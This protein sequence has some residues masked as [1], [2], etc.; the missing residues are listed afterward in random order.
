MEHDFDKKYTLTV[1]E[2]QAVLIKDAL[3]EYFRIRMNQW[4]GLAESLVM[5]NI[6]LSTD[7][8]NHEKIFERYIAE[9]DSVRNV[10]ECA[11]RIL[12]ENQRNPKSEEQL[13]AEDIWQ[14]IRHQ[15][16]KES[17]NKNDWCVDSREPLRMSDEPLPEMK[18]VE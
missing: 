12:W 6:D 18:K 1:T 5:K 10:L 4:G 17:E 15:L 11:G 14:V 16:W 9:R 2:K 7:N 8:S 3:E 13:I